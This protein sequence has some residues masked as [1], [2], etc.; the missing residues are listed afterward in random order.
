VPASLGERIRIIQGD[1][2]DPA[3]VAGAV[4]D[5]EVVF[6]LGAMISIPYS[7]VHPRETIETNVLGTLNVL[8]A[9]R[10]FG[11]GRMLCASS[12]EVYGTALYAPIDEK[13]PLQ[14]QSPYSASKIAAEMLTESFFRAYELPVTIVRPFNTYGPRQSARAVVPTIITQALAGPEVQLGDVTATRDLMYVADNVAGFLR[15]AESPD[16]RGQVVNLGTGT[17]VTIEEVV[18]RVGALL[19]KSLTIVVDSARIRPQRSEVRRLVADAS[20]ARALGWAPAVD[21]DEGLRRTIAFIRDAASLYRPGTYT[22]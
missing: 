16:A 6:H 11:V 15:L 3:A 5:S 4:R 9:C 20:R 13:H 1:L 21:L 10:E 12:S 8:N 18:K 17:E 2:R 14:G 19:G 7:Y 22:I